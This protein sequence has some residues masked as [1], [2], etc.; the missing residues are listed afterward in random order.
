MSGGYFVDWRSVQA[1]QR[2]EMVASI[3]LAVTSAFRDVD[4]GIVVATAALKWQAGVTLFAVRRFPNCSTTC[5]QS[6]GDRLSLS[7][8]GGTVFNTEPRLPGFNT[9]FFRAI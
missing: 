8:I 4:L 5:I 9:A 2:V 3:R 6:S 1:Q 7:R